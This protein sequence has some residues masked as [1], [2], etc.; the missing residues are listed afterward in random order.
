MF[1]MKP[2]HEINLNLLVCLHALYEERNVTRAAHRLNMTQ[3]NVSK[4]L[5]QLRRIMHDHLLYREDNTLKLTPLSIAIRDKV[6]FIVQNAQDVFSAGLRGSSLAKQR[7][8]LAA[9]DVSVR[10]V[11]PKL[12]PRFIEEAPDAL[13]S[14]SPW[15]EYNPESLVQGKVDLALCV[16]EEETNGLICEKLGTT[17]LSCIVRKEHPATDGQMQLEDYLSYR[18]IANTGNAN[19]WRII[20]KALAERGLQRNIV[21]EMPLVISVTEV[22]EQSDLVLTLPTPLCRLISDNQDLCMI[23]CPVKTLLDYG[24]MWHPRMDKDPDH[25]WFRNLIRDVTFETPEFVKSLV[26]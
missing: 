16:F 22:V 19:Y 4:S 25:I 8:T 21:L 2:L 14:L 7:F 1:S 26:A 3:S 24:L 9:S 12:M 5:S 23:D 11:F 17:D 13:I 6:A 15:H 10:Y 20:D 18:H